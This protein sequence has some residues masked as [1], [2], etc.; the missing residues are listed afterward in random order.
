MG[1]NIVYWGIVWYVVVYYDI[2][3]LEGYT[4]IV[5]NRME[6]FPNVLL[7]FRGERSVLLGRLRISGRVHKVAIQ[8]AQASSLRFVAACFRVYGLGLRA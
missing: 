5:E 6:T 2:L 1:C 8:L 7:Q 3:Y 4:G